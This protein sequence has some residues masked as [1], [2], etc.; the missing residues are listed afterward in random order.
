[1]KNITKIALST[2]L[3]TSSTLAFASEQDWKG[4]SLDAWVD[5]KAE[6]TLLLNAELNSFNIDTDVEDGIVTLTGEV[7]STLEKSLAEEL[8]KTLDGVK[9]VENK[10]T[11]KDETAAV[12]S[13]K[14][15]VTTNVT[16]SLLMS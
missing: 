14:N 13:E 4:E 12:S 7:N 8:I 2:V 1:M 10:L 9:G 11:I 6:T 3:L 5:G 16:N 15:K